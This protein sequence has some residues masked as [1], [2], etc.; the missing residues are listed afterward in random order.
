[1]LQM[2]RLGA[3]AALVGGALLLTSRTGDVRSG[4]V[5]PAPTS[6]AALAATSGDETIVFAGGCF[7]G[8]Q[9]VFEHV[10]GVKSAVS[11]Y[12]GGTVVSPS[13]ED[14]S[15]GTTGHAESV[16]VAF[17]PS[18]VSLGQLLQVFFSV[19]HDPT[20]K[21]RQ[22]PDVGTQY[23]SAIFYRTDAQRPVIDAYIKQ[24]TDAKTFS[25]P[26]VTQVAPLSAFYVAESYHQHYAMLHPDSPYIYTYDL[27]KVAA[28]KAQFA[29]L[30]R[31]DVSSDK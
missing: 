15:S 26:I 29:S 30:Y 10:R 8:I 11:G 5:L 6:G 18:Q 23:R 24:L 9:A 1:M 13:Y 17:D 16:E 31:E 28:L 4:V 19:A 22:G 7:W 27:P 3:A 12:A 25:R 14:V 21:N 2:T 20:Q